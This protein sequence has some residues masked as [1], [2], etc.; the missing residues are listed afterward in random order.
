MDLTTLIVIPPLKIN[1][2]NL[3]GIDNE[4]VFGFVTFQSVSWLKFCMPMIG[5]VGKAYEIKQKWQHASWLLFLL[6][7][8]IIIRSM[9]TFWLTPYLE[10]L[11]FVSFI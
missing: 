7:Y 11:T 4:T 1:Q 2:I 9:W 10:R 3:S 5:P 6:R 8:M